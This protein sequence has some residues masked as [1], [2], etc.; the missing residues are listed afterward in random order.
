MQQAVGGQPP[1]LQAFFDAIGVNAVYLAHLLRCQTVDEYARYC[2]QRH[3]EENK[4]R[5]AQTIAAKIE[6]EGI[7]YYMCSYATVYGGLSPTLFQETVEKMAAEEWK[8]PSENSCHDSKPV[9]A[10]TNE[11]AAKR[12]C[13]DRTL[14]EE[15]DR[16]AT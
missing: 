1:I 4:Y 11:P 6:T 15:H 2:V 8:L 7:G 9:D 3:A 13:F 10:L 14:F 16:S 12:P 5:D